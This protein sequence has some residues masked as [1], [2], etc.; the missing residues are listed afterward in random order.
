MRAGPWS[1]GGG[2]CFLW[3]NELLGL[4]IV[5][6]A[7]TA[8]AYFTSPFARLV[9]IRKR[10]D[11]SFSGVVAWFG[12]FIFL[13]GATHVMSIWIIYQPDYWPEGVI[14]ALTVLV[15]VLITALVWPLLPKALAV[16]SIEQTLAINKRL[17]PAMPE[18]QQA[19]I[20]AEQA[21]GAKSTFLPICRTNSGPRSMPLS[22]TAK[23]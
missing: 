21:S 11:M 22:A 13:C 18:V 17:E 5:A 3:K 14:K 23:C 10:P 20:E 2:Y 19:R 8:L 1:P 4:H 6:D 9:L 7:L 16:P 12:L 15:S